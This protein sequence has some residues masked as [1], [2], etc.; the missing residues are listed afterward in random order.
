MLDRTTP[1]LFQTIDHLK[2][3]WPQTLL[4]KAGIPL[5]VLNAG[6]Q[7]IIKLELVFENGTWHEPSNGVA[8][9]TAKMLLEGTQHKSAQDIARYIDQYGASLEA[10][11]QPDRCSITLITLS[12]YLEP[13]LIL[14][15]ELLLDPAFAEQRLDH[16]K[17]LTIQALKVDDEKSSHVAHKK[18]KEVLFSAAHSYGKSLTAAAIAAITPTHLKQ[19]YDCQLLAGCCIFM[20]GRIDEQDIVMVQRHLQ[21]LPM[22][23]SYSQSPSSAVQPP[24]QVHLLQKGRL[25]AAINM[26][27]VLFTKNHPDYLPMLFLNTLLG[28]YFGS[29]LMHNIRE[30][31]GYTYGIYSRI[32]ALKY[33]SYLVIA[34]EVMQEFTQAVCQEIEQEIKALQTT[35]VPQEELQKLRN[36]MLGDFLSEV[37]D[38]FSVMEKF[39]AAHLYGLDQQYYEHF[40][41]TIS[42][43]NSAHIMA[44]ANQYLPTDSLS[45]VIVG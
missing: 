14:L 23:A 41:D 16:L 29:R 33:T 25:Q 19:Y 22:H 42:H 21:A 10:K 32:I 30:Q 35:P 3:P 38:P 34:T 43:I 39:K 4:L 18:F 1:P 5:F 9:F 24:A 44:L 26:G 12:K 15:A 40:Y 13:M 20:S 28:G 31:K 2:L 11:V 27:K 7:P 6:Q 17:H 37:N 8:Y 45:R 36:Y